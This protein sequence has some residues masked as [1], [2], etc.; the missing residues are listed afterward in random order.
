MWPTCVQGKGERNPAEPARPRQG[1][2]EGGHAR[3]S[4]SGGFGHGGSEGGDVT[5]F[6]FHTHHHPGPLF[7]G[8]SFQ[9]VLTSFVS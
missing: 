5:C 3:A 9:G 1:A 2:G 7:K 6:A 4:N 8:D